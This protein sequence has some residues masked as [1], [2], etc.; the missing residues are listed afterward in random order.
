MQTE[1]GGADRADVT[2]ADERW[3]ARVARGVEHDKK[4]KKRAIAAAGIVASGLTL[5]V[6]IVSCSVRPTT[7]FGIPAL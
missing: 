4:T 1:M 7:T 3:A 5:W 2:T 6:T